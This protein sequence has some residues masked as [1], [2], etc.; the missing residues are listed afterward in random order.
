[1]LTKCML[2]AGGMKFWSHSN[3]TIKRQ[4][5]FKRNKIHYSYGADVVNAMASEVVFS[6]MGKIGRLTLLDAG[7]RQEEYKIKGNPV[8]QIGFFNRVWFVVISH[9]LT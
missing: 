4:N 8:K 1:M 6:G 3:S 5:Y 7:N 9:E 2:W